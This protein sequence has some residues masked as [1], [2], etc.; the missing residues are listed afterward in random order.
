MRR[1]RRGTERSGGLAG[2]P[3]GSPT[4]AA[5]LGLFGELLCCRSSA[6]KS[7]HCGAAGRSLT[8]DL[9]LAGGYGA[10]N[11]ADPFVKRLGGPNLCLGVCGVGPDGA[12]HGAAADA[13]RRALE[14]VQGE[15][16]GPNRAV[17]S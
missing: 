9:A 6:G 15:T 14:A 12:H 2:R 13:L 1:R 16:G 5:S 11:H 3:R 10:K 8:L 7:T 4:L 17:C